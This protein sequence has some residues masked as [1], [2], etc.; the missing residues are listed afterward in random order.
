MKV[1]VQPL[2]HLA[3]IDFIGEFA[4]TN[5]GFLFYQCITKSLH[6]YIHMQLHYVHVYGHTIK[7]LL[8]VREQITNILANVEESA[9]KH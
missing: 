7:L 3:K 8:S 5:Q 1:V 6:M 4:N 2:K 9:W